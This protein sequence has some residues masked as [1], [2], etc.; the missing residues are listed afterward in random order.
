MKRHQAGI[1]WTFR[2]CGFSLSGSPSLQG[3]L[4][5][6]CCPSHCAATIWLFPEGAG[7]DIAGGAMTVAKATGVGSTVGL[8]V[9]QDSSW[10]HLSDTQ[11]ARDC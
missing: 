1:G 7:G 2:R 10:H 6:A 3:L 9:L 8:V 4:G 11:P 5:P